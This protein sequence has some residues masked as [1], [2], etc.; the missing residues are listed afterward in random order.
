VSPSLARE[1]L[2]KLVLCACA[3][4]ENVLSRCTGSSFCS[5][6]YA[7]EEETTLTRISPTLCAC[8]TPG[9]GGTTDT[10]VTELEDFEDVAEV[11]EE[12]LIQLTLL[13]LVL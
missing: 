2:E 13:L 3:G 7:A 4:F 5:S 1:R 10:S 11:D 9:E 6:L 12:V 8:D